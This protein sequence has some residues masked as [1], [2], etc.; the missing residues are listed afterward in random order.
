[1]HNTAPLSTINRAGVDKFYKTLTADPQV[2]ALVGA[3]VYAGKFIIAE[4]S[5]GY[6]AYLICPNKKVAEQL[7]EKST[8]LF[9]KLQVVFP[10]TRILISTVDDPLHD[11]VLP[12]DDCVNDG[13]YQ[14]L[15]DLVLGFGGVKG[16]PSW[17]I[18]VRLDENGYIYQ[19]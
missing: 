18:V 7:A 2:M 9:L 13:A 1:M 12:F 3:V 14:L 17:H 10:I 15:P 5:N 8:Y 6:H 19:P 4:T 16:H 11:Q